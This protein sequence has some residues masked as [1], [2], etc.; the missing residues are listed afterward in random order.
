LLSMLNNYILFIHA[1]QLFNSLYP[2]LSFYIYIVKA[3][4]F[5]T[6]H[7]ITHVTRCDRLL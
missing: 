4:R 1:Y 6:C 7:Y 3:E 5:C 2:A